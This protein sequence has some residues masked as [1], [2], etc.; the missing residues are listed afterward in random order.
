MNP[1]ISSSRPSTANV[2][3]AIGSALPVWCVGQAA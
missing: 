3:L 2:V 1:P